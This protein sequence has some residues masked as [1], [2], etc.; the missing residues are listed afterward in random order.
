MT[1]GEKSKREEREGGKVEGTDWMER[2]RKRKRK[3]KGHEEKKEKDEAG[4][5]RGKGRTK[6]VEKN[7]EWERFA[8]ISA[9]NILRI[10]ISLRF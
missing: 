9:I 1:E 4:K 3:R 7:I 2:K 10:T 8:I 6:A 5:R